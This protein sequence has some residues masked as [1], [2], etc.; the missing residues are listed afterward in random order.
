MQRTRKRPRACWQGEGARHNRSYANRQARSAA[1][2]WRKP[3]C[4]TPC[5]VKAHSDLPSPCGLVA[6]RHV[7]LCGERCT[8]RPGLVRSWLRHHRACSIAPPTQAGQPRKGS[9]NVISNPAAKEKTACPRACAWTRMRVWKKIPNCWRCDF[10]NSAQTAAASGEN[11]LAYDECTSGRVEWQWDN[12][13][14]FA[15]NVP[16]ENPAGQGQFS[17]PLRF[18]G[19]YYDRET[20]L[21]YNYF[22]DYDPSIGRYI[23]SDPAGLGGGVNTYTYVNGNPISFVDPKGLWPMYGCWTGSNWSGCSSGPDIP[24][25]PQE[26]VD[27]V[28]ACAKQHDYCYAQATSSSSSCSANQPP[29][30]SSCDTQL[31]QC[32]EK[33][34]YSTIKSWKGKFIGPYVTW[35]AAI[36]ARISR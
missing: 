33:I 16:N 12:T 21:H 1:E 32:T 2:W 20:N 18:A 3:L 29:T 27:E 30:I 22:R 14:S 7:G 19:Q 10:I 13:D 15:S 34:N 17:F 23:E 24:A 35:W 11:A 36:H 6:A 25:N 8:P 9:L 28:D 5:Y 4:I 31:A 26:P